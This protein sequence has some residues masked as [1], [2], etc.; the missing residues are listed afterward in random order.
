[1]LSELQETKHRFIF[2]LMDFDNNGYIEL[3]DF[4]AIAENLC[5]VRGEEIDS[6]ESRYIINRCHVLWDGLAYYID[7][8]KDNKCTIDEWLTFIDSHLIN[9]GQSEREQHIESVVSKLFDLYDTNG[10]EY[11]SLN[12]YLDIFLSFRL[13]SSLVAKSFNTLDVNHDQAIS[14]SE[15]IGTVI[16]FLVS[17]DLNVPGNWIFGDLY[18][19]VV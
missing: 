11:I 7:E 5:L 14:K 8:N 9:T 2:N 18:T 13:N 12:E 4:L 16:D 6:D 1:M 10:D 19:E 17:D 15:L 3:E